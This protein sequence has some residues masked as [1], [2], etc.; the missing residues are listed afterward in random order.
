MASDARQVGIF[1]FDGV[2]LLCTS[3]P[4]CLLVSAT[5]QLQRR[6][7]R[8]GYDIGYFSASGGQVMTKQGLPVDTKPLG[9]VKASDLDTVILPG[10]DSDEWR[11]PVIVD[12]LSRNR[13]EVRRFAGISCG[14]FYLAYAGLLD[15]RSATTHWDECDM[16]ESDFPSVNVVR[17]SIYIHDGQFWT[18]A[19]AASGLDVALAMVEED[20]GHELAMVIASLAVMMMKR[21]G[22]DPQLTPQLQSQSIE[23]PMAPLL[24][25]I[26]ENPDADLRT[27]SLAE[28]ANMSV[29]NLYRAFAEATGAPPAEWVENVRL[30]VAKR[31]L[32]QTEERVD[33]IALK[34]GFI[35]EQRMR[36]C[37][38]RKVGISPLVYRARFAQPAPAPNAEV[39]VSLLA[40]AYGLAGAHAKQTLA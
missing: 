29:R 34:S 12:W 6:G 33:Q 13:N 21:P 19:G 36:R 32:E 40:D 26:V 8:G 7:E 18:S 1:L 39:D 17:D 37:F 22:S 38:V 5:R 23:G 4:A 14:T 15:G 11:D 28:R 10:G 25:W 20:H 2:D 31:L 3:G 30:G 35:D 9:E 16:L 27:E 24:K